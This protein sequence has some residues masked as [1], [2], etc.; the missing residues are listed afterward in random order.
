MQRRSTCIFCTSS[1]LEDVLQTDQSIPESIT[2][3]ASSDDASWMPFN[4][5]HCTACHAYQT[6]YLADINVLYG[7][8][9]I[10][11]IGRIR[12]EM[13][14][15]FTELIT[16]NSH[17][18]GIM[19]IGGG[20]GTLSDALLPTHTKYYIIDPSYTGNTE[21]RCIIPYVVEECDQSS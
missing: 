19:E 6:K 12:K 16:R 15:V 18:Q 1:N 2:I 4:I 13:D 8:S 9:H 17:V 20:N 11:P 3:T 7:E 10:H 14:T 5:Q 21:N